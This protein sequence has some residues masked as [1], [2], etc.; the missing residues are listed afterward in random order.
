M[1]KFSEIK[2]YVKTNLPNDRF[3]YSIIIGAIASVHVFLVLLFILLRVLPLVIFNIC[4]VAAYA[5]CL[6]AIKIETDK[7]L[8]KFFYITYFEIILHSI[9]ATILVGWRFGFPQYISGLIPFGFYIC[10]TLLNCST[11]KKYFIA[12]SFG[13]FA[14]FSYIGCRIISTYAGSV[15]QLNVPT[16]VELLIYIF[17]AV[18]NFTFLFMVTLIFIIDMQLSANKLTDQNAIL[19][20]M[21]S[22]DPLTGLYNRRSM[23]AFFDHAIESEEPFCLVMCD[24]DDFKK[25]N[26]NYGH[27]FGDIVLKEVTHIIHELE[28]EHGYV[29]RWGGEEILILSTENL[30]TTCKIAENIRRNVESHNFLYNGK[31]IHCTLTIGVASHKQGNTIADTIMHAD[32]RLYYGKKN[33]KNRVVTPYDAA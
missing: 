18:C 3:K 6:N 10:V 30:D 31:I 7:N 15:Y 14:A 5:Y 25:C 4:S 11:K 12:I 2:E 32:N 17:N 29:C 27:D 33:G 8:I 1:K 26:D 16:I 22:V 21:A 28:T 20:K 13:L 24:I 19:D 23:Q 9:F